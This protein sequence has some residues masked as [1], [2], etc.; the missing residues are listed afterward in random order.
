MDDVFIIGHGRSLLS[1]SEEEREYIRSRPSFTTSIYLL[2]YEV[3][4][5]VPD[6]LV[7]PSPVD[8]YPARHI[9][10]GGSVLGAAT[11]CE[12]HKLKTHW[13]VHEQ[14]YEYLIN[15]KLTK[16]FWQK[17]CPRVGKK[18]VHSR[19]QL[20]DFNP[21]FKMRGVPNIPQGLGDELRRKIPLL[22][23]FRY[24]NQLSLH[25]LPEP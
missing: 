4:N 10:P 9:T 14:L 20:P 8:D 17:A 24:S 19:I 21:S 12:K 15:K 22:I 25:T 13:Y 23:L 5:I 18:P 16:S 6:Y 1:L 2:F 7:L 3:L 11:V